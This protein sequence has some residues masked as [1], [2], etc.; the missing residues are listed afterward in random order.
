MVVSVADNAIPPHINKNHAAM[1]YDQRN[2]IPPI[3]VI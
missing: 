1:Q 3:I 2:H